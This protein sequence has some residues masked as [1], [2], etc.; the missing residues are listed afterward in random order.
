MKTKSI[1]RELLL[2]AVLTLSFGAAS[3][4]APL[5]QCEYTNEKLDEVV[6]EGGFSDG[7]SAY[8]VDITVNNLDDDALVTG[9]LDKDNKITFKKPDEDFYVRF[10]AGPGHVIEV[11]QKE[12]TVPAPAAK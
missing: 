7:S 8:G 6:C 11:D 2:G 5:L 10:D 12:I 9:K 3:A 4:H 1:T